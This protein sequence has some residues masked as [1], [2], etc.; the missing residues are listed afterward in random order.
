MSLINFLDQ[1]QQEDLL[2]KDE[3]DTLL[4]RRDA[5]GKMTKFSKMLAVSALPLGFIGAFAKP[6]KAQSTG[7]IVDVLNFALTVEHLENEY[8]MTGVAE[9]GLIPSGKDADIFAQVQ[10]HEE[11]HVN[12]LIDVI[13]SLG[14]EPIEKPTFDFT[15]G[16]AFD[17]FNNY[18]QYTALAQAFEDTGVRAYKGQAATVQGNAGI[19]TAALQI[20]SVEAR[21]A[22]E[23]RRLRGIKGWI[24][25]DQ[26]GDGMPPQTQPVYD[27]EDVATQLGI[28]LTE[29]SDVKR[30]R[31]TQAWDEPLTMEE[32]NAIAGLFI[33]S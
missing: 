26:R 25:E 18:D 16:G 28:D 23:I 1:L 20:H 24:T 7:E 3:K 14:G 4:N 30:H 12:F 2:N 32:A 33:V 31:I 29:V 17:P 22:S 15:V 19:L 8:Y 11:Q 21:H 13:E 27:G 6:A 5:F 9:S 10:K